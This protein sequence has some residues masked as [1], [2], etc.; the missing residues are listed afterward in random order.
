MTRAAPRRRRPPVA[1]ALGRTAAG[2][3]VV[4]A[5]SSTAAQ[6]RAHR[7]C[8]W[9]KL[10]FR[11]WQARRRRRK[12]PRSRGRAQSACGPAAVRSGRAV[13]RRRRRRLRQWQRSRRRVRSLRRRCRRLWRLGPVITASRPPRWPQGP[14]GLAIRSAARSSQPRRRRP[15]VLRRSGRPA[16]AVAHGAPGMQGP[17]PWGAGGARGS[18]WRQR[19]DT[20]R[21]RRT[22][23]AALQNGATGKG[24]AAQCRGEKGSERC[25]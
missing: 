12:G 8:G 20:R 7:A 5:A 11:R 25:V 1:G 15:P 21:S 16:A 10:S 19:P 6:T 22:R 14:H 24:E 4:Q 9:T 2:A 13:C 18:L 17:L 23:V 3:S